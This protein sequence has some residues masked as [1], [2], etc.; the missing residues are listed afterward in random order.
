MLNEK[1][2]DMLMIILLF[3]TPG[4]DSS[5]INSLA[6]YKNAQKPMIV[7]TMGG[8]FTRLH[9]SIIEANGIPVYMSPNSAARALKALY[10]YSHHFPK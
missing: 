1:N 5:I 8:A 9:K 4:A 6:K 10:D 7:V 3:Q 2:V